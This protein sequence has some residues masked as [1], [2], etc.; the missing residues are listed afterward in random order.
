M[1]GPPCQRARVFGKRMAGSKTVP[2]VSR[3]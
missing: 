3:T 1:T 2:Q